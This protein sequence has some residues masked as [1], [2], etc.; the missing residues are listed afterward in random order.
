MDQETDMDKTMRQAGD[1]IA[2]VAE[3]TTAGVGGVVQDLEILIR[4]YPWQ[5]G[6][7]HV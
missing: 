2:D 5:I 7:A 4:R 6:R 3:K 1:T